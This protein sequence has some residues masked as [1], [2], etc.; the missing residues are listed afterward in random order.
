MVLKECEDAIKLAHKGSTFGMDMER[1][2]CLWCKWAIQQYPGIS[3]V[4]MA[5]PV[6]FDKKL[7]SGVDQMPVYLVAQQVFYF[8]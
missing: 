1:A 8:I 2:K 6:I 3:G 7:G 5:T 4:Q